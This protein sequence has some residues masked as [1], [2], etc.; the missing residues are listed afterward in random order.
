LVGAVQLLRRIEVPCA[1]VVLN[2]TASDAVL[3]A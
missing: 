2:D 1:G 3:T